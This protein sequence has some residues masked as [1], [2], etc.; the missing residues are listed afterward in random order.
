PASAR[1]E[2]AGEA[3]LGVD[4]LLFEWLES[5]AG[6]HVQLSQH[7]D[8]TGEESFDACDRV[9][10]ADAE[11]ARLKMA[12]EALLVDEDAGRHDRVAEQGPELVL[13]VDGDG[14]GCSCPLDPGLCR[15]RSLRVGRDREEVDRAVLFI[16][17]L[18][19]GQLRAAASPGRP[20]EQDVSASLV[21]G[22][23]GWV[24]IERG[25]EDGGV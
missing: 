6:L 9:L 8:V 18:P 16:P 24:A 11:V 1:E 22:K 12:H 21:A 17:V 7:S 20:D 14:E 23:L 3:Y 4:E 15:F 19:H 10:V 2:F 13:A 25:V 5:A